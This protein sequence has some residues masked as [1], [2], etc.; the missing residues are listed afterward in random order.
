MSKRFLV[1]S[2]IHGS[3]KTLEAVL[4]WAKGIAPDAAVFLGDGISD[5]GRV[6]AATGFPCPWQMVRGNNDFASQCQEA[7]IFDF[8]GHRFFICHGHRYNLY[9]TTETLVAAARNNN[10]NAALFGHTHVPFIDDA[11]GIL[12]LNPGCIGNPRSKIGPTFAVIE[13]TPGNPLKPEFWGI[14][15]AGNISAV[16]VGNSL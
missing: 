8:A 16:H 5:L 1:L 7:A 14:D 15:A 6:T 10:A 12:L 13:C 9:T 4:N 2:D 3:V 11:G